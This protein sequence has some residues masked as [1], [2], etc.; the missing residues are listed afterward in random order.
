VNLAR[1]VKATVLG[2]GRGDA[3]TFDL[4]DLPGGFSSYH[5][6]EDVRVVDDEDVQARLSGEFW[7][8]L[9]WRKGK[10]PKAGQIDTID[11]YVQFPQG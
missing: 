3:V 7:I 1:T 9:V 11:L 5:P 4:R 10:A 2:D 8:T 6:P